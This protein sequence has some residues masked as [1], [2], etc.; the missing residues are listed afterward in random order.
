MERLEREHSSTWS[1]QTQY[2][3]QQQQQAPKKDDWEITIERVVAHNVKFQ[4]ETRNNHKNTTTSIKNLE[5]QMGQIAQQLASSSRA[6][7]ALPSATMTN[8]RERNNVSVMTTRSDKSDEV[9]DE[10]DKEED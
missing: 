7:C 8:L 2:Q 6:Q 4:E 1:Y 9:V 10:M 3:Q 5:V